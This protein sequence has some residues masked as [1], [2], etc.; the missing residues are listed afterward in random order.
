MENL[1]ILGRRRWITLTINYDT[2]DELGSLA[3]DTLRAAVKEVFKGEPVSFVRQPGA[4]LCFGVSA[5]SVTDL[6][7][8]SNATQEALKR[9]LR[10]YL[11]ESR[12]N[13]WEGR[14]ED[15]TILY[16]DIET[17]DA[18]L[19]WNMPLSE[20]F[21]LGQFS[22][23]QS[24]DVLLVE[25]YREVLEA[26]KQ[27]NGIVAHN[28]HPFDFSVLLGNEALDL[29]LDNRLFDTMVYANLAYPSPK[30]F[31][32]RSGH[33]VFTEGKPEAVSRWLSLDNLAFQFDLPG[34]EG[35]LKALA[36]EFGGFGAIPVSDSRYRAYAK[37]DIHM[38][39]GITN[40]LLY[41]H[42]PT[43][44]D[45]RDQLKAA[46]DA[47]MS[48]N[49]FT[50][51]IPAAQERI[52][53]L[54]E[55]KAELMVSLVNDYGLPSAGKMPWRTKTGK[56]AVVSALAKFGL[57]PN[58]IADWPQ[59][60]TGPSLSGPVI[61]EFTKGTEAED[62]GITLAEL[63]G[64]RSLAEQA[65]TYTQNDGKMHP[66]IN[67]WQMSGRRSVT[68][69]GLTTW[70]ERNPRDKRYLVASQGRK[71]VEF[72]LSNADQ[73]I[74][75]AFCGDPEYAKRFIPGADGHE[76]SGR[77]MYG[78]LTYDSDSAKYRQI[79]KALSHAWAYG[80]GARK[81]AATAKQPLEVAERFISAMRAA[82]PM[83]IDWQ[84]KVRNDGAK[85]YV[86]NH[87]G[88][89][90][91]VDKDRAYTQAP[92][93]HGQSGTTEVLY[94]GLIKMA[95]KDIRLIHW[96][97]CPIHDAIL[98]DIPEDEI[99]YARAAVDECMTQTINGIEFPVSSGPAGDTWEAARH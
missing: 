72:D 71:L 24:G 13:P 97:V 81:L 50:V 94:D 28:G 35:D 10:A 4:A 64:Q 31:T 69:A 5:P 29:A 83:L 58:S 70:G 7:I 37:Q 51:D 74:V 85:G 45:W 88:R 22:F 98:M 65:L 96:L 44:Y 25:D 90:I 21:R 23:G 59:L 14:F 52:Q 2:T 54:A 73:R 87:W 57:D 12:K 76:I 84:D 20:F 47:Q 16:L 48:R 82:Y 56:A 66:D 40:E 55:R 75:A 17:H 9:L 86:L 32:M 92:A 38:L 39:K 46:I 79:A 78:N 42:E 15:A 18:K 61:V 60:K 49:G 63:Q 36:K 27:A 30:L 26:C 91:I 43:A 68:H 1:S 95:R 53:E 3:L 34:K 80:S 99:D 6:V 93:A 62:F 19:R 77:L 8:A 89:K 67:G 33:K 41:I 11:P